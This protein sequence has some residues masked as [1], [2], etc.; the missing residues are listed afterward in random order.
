MIAIDMQV[1]GL[2]ELQ[3]KLARMDKAIVDATDRALATIGQRLHDHLRET[4]PVLSGSY[5]D[6]IALDIQPD[7]TVK[8]SVSVDHALAVEANQGTFNKAVA[9][10]ASQKQIFDEIERE[11]ALIQ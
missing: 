10:V 5:R 11:L 8:V 7:G 4:A 3:A 6:S 1:K 9:A 2:A